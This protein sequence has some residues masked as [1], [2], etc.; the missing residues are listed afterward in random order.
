[1]IQFITG[2]A[3]QA[4]SHIAVNTQIDDV[5]LDLDTVIPLGF[6]VTELVT[7]CFKHA[8]SDGKKGTIWVYFK[9]IS[10]NDFELR[11]EDNGVGLNSVHSPEHSKSMGLNLV[12]VFAQQLDTDL[13]ISSNNGTQVR[14]II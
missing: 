10:E 2:T 8:F 6:I 4:A 1:M 5:N 7:N 3:D 9:R 12:R 14:L 13:S 11:I